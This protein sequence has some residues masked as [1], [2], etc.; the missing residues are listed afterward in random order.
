MRVE[1][2]RQGN[3]TFRVPDKPLNRLLHQCQFRWQL[4]AGTLP[5]E[6]V[7]GLL[8]L[9]SSLA[10]TDVWSRPEFAEG[11]ASLPRRRIAHEDSASECLARR[12]YVQLHLG[13]ADTVVRKVAFHVFL[14]EV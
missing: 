9:D 10:A 13:M 6:Q 5:A 1:G 3:L 8:D 11:V 7:L 14:A 2:G 4:P 12:I